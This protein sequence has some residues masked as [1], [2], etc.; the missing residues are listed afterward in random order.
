MNFDNTTVNSIQDIPLPSNPSLNQ[1]TM[2]NDHP[3]IH[4]KR[5]Q[6]RNACTN[7][8]KACKKCDD[9]RPCP[10]CIRY[11]L[12]DTCVSSTRKERKKG[13]KRGP[14]KQRETSP[15]KSSK[16]KNI[17]QNESPN[18]NM[19]HHLTNN[20]NNSNHHHDNPNNHSNVP[21]TST[22][23]P[24]S[25]PIPY[26]TYPP[27]LNQYHYEGYNKLP[28]YM[29]GPFAYPPIMHFQ[30][31]PPPPHHFQQQQPSNET[32]PQ[33]YGPPPP[34][35]MNQ[36]HPETPYYIPP[37]HINEFSH[38]AFSKENHSETHHNT[39]PMTPAPSTSTSST[40]SPHTQGTEDEPAS[41]NR[42]S[43]LCSAALDNQAPE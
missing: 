31:P 36:Q 2:T 34:G 5:R 11:N 25:H 19:N 24:S 40:S 20:E 9:A 14:Y 22:Y 10:R 27:H 30:H 23:P 42:L 39:Q 32:N 18:I 38:L 13:V 8:Q 26:T 28:P 4:T 12:S 21:T 37:Q 35:L 41:M 17:N 29:V 15:T 16:K 43:Q 3:E 7:C 1:V 33:P 6:V